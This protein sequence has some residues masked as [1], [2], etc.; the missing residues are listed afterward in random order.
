VSSHARPVLATLAVLL[1]A[2]LASGCQAD[3]GPERTSLHAPKDDGERQAQAAVA[4]LCETVKAAGDLPAAR[5]VFYN[6][7]HDGLHVL[8]AMV[9]ERDREAAA[10]LAEATNTVEIDFLYADQNPK[11]KPHLTA[12]LTAASDALAAA[13]IQ[14]PACAR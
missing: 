11:L 7:A 4:G 8:N 13:G 1:A 14:P 12:L 10:R 6:Q 2:T 9:A 3:A 5:V